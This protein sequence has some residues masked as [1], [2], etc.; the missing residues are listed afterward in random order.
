MFDFQNYIFYNSDNIPFTFFGVMIPTAPAALSPESPPL[1]ERDPPVSPISNDDLSTLDTDDPIP[2][3]PSVGVVDGNI[4]LDL[5]WL[6]KL[7]DANIST[8]KDT[9]KQ[10]T[11][12][13]DDPYYDPDCGIKA[14]EARAKRPK[15]PPR[16][17]ADPWATGTYKRVGDDNV[18]GMWD[19]TDYNLMQR[20][21]AED[22]AL[23]EGRRTGTFVFPVYDRWVGSQAS[24]DAFL[25][26][27]VKQHENEKFTEQD[28]DVD[29]C[30]AIFKKRKISF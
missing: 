26:H 9:E 29:N 23:E 14:M 20:K 4:V 13:K 28:F 22:R 18:F 30:A 25:N 16:V 8:L 7:I 1:F 11:S 12:N 27:K 5:D 19:Y 6:D 10:V 2:P 24:Y 15:S 3:P 17:L 21:K